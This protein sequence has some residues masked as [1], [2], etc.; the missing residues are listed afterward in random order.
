MPVKHAFTSQ[1]SDNDDAGDIQPSDFNADHVLTGLLQKLDTVAPTPN[2]VFALDANNNP[3]MMAL[4]LLARLASPAFTG[5]PTVPTATAGDASTKIANTQF[6]GT[7]ITA[8]INALQNGAPAA[9][10]TLKELADAINDDASYAATLTSL[11]TLKAPLLSPAFTGS[12]TVPTPT[13]GDNSTKIANTAALIA[14]LAAYAPL[15]SPTFTGAP[16][17]PTPSGGDNSTK[18]A[19]TAF[20]QSALSNGAGAFGQCQLTKSGSNLVLNRYRGKLLTIG[21]IA[22]TIPAAGV[23]LAPTGLTVGATYYIYATQSG[24]IVNALEASPTGHSTDTAAGNEGVEIK[25][26][27]ATRTL[28]GQARVI[29]GPAWQDAANQ[30][31]VRSW[32]HDS[33]VCAAQ[34]ISSGLLVSAVSPAE[35]STSGRVEMLL[36]AGEHL[37]AAGSVSALSNTAGGYTYVNLGVDTA[38]TV[39]GRQIYFVA[40]N[41]NYYSDVAVTGAGTIGSEGYHF[42]TMGGCVGSGTNSTFSDQ[43]ISVTTVRK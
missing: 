28:V 36:W 15:L 14:A 21:G 16:A 10:D 25:T 3:I 4:S 12:P 2:T 37:A 34:G 1:R 29:S 18:L 35:L 17:A 8:A 20:V 31:F 11:L 32:F 27:D 22:A 43:S 41:A 38:A 26:G 42:V 39:F 7:A 40:V 23:T 19:T 5:A 9:L 30:R 6:V 33:G 13:L 24:G